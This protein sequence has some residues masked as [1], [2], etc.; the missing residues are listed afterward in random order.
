MLVR[1]S[2]NL[3]TTWLDPKYLR[4]FLRANLQDVLYLII[5]LRGLEMVKWNNCRQKFANGVFRARKDGWK[6]RLLIDAWNAIMVFENSRRDDLPISGRKG[7]LLRESMHPLHVAKSDVDNYYGGLLMPEWRS[8]YIALL[9][10]KI[11]LGACGQE[12]IHSRW[13]DITQYI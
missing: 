10:I 4:P 6:K 9:S 1:L 13:Y 11:N 3:T 7:D 12:N 2:G 5:R 8:T